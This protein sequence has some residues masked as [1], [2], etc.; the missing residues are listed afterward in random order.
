MHKRNY[1]N[2]STQIFIAHPENSL[3]E[4]H[5]VLSQMMRKAGLP[6]MQQDVSTADIE[7]QVAEYVSQCYCAVLVLGDA[8]GDE[9]ATTGVSATEYQYRICRERLQKDPSFKLF[10]WNISTEAGLSQDIRQ[11]DFIR[12]IMSELV[13]GIQF[14]NTGSAVLLVD[15]IRNALNEV[16]QSDLQLNSTDIF[17][18]HNQDDEDTAMEIADMLSDIIPVEKMNIIQDDDRDYPEHCSQ[19][20]SKS[21][22]AVIYFKYAGD[23]AVPFVQQI[24]K[25]VGGASS[26]TPIL[27]IGDDDPSEN[28]QR[29]FRA[30]KV[31][32][33]VMSGALIPLEIKV[34]FDK[35]NGEA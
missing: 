7:R 26:G 15:D 10:I 1:L 32:S 29:T 17:L 18:V 14:S 28:L 33:L 3:R 22:L 8:Y 24:W 13:S 9:L 23:W 25:K 16:I 19:Q 6:V 31:T 34:Q 12:K 5:E 11:R 21:K 27:L 4:N 2:L 35:A 20:I 30:A